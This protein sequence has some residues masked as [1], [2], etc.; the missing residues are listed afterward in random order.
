[1]SNSV[2]R[3]LVVIGT[4]PEAIK[5]APLIAELRQRPHEFKTRVCVTGQHRSMLD[6]VLEFFRIHVDHD[7]AVMQSNQTPCGVISRVLEG[8]EPVIEKTKP[9]LIVVQGDTTSALAGALAGFYNGIDVCHVEA[10]LR[11]GDFSSPY[12]EEMNR[13]LI[14]RLTRFHFAPTQ[15]SARALVDEGCAPGSVSIVGNTGIDALLMALPLLAD[16]PT[17]RFDCEIDWT[18]RVVLVTGHRRES[19]GAGFRSICAALETLARRN[20]DVTFVF[21]L[22]L[23]PKVRRPVHAALRNEA[24]IVLLEP[25]D[26][27]D[28][29]RCLARSYIVLTDSGGIQEEAPSLGKPVLVMRKTT[30]RQE[31]IEAGT[32]KLVGTDQASIDSEVQHLLDDPASYAAM[33]SATN[34]Y[35]DGTTSTQIADILAKA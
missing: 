1:M 25:L 32:A 4:R 5:L 6:H 19:F 27:P 23:N 10:G 8:V 18:Q 12:P 26:Y 21:P 11:T 7:L 17:V 20:R 34:P 29:V 30:E 35:G 22:H 15:R 33:A 3:I 9:D 24:N 16:R 2:K 13:V 31:G 14:A 28:F